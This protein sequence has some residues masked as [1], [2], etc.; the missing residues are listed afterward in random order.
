MYKDLHLQN[1]TITPRNSRT[2]NVVMNS[3]KDNEDIE[4]GFDSSG[5]FAEHSEP[6]Y[7]T[8]SNLAAEEM[9]GSKNKME[10]TYKTDGDFI[11]DSLILPQ[12]QQQNASKKKQV[13]GYSS[14]SNLQDNSDEENNGSA[15]LST[16]Y[17]SDETRFMNGAVNGSLLQQEQ[18]QQQTNGVMQKQQEQ[19]QKPKILHPGYEADGN[20]FDI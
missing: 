3:Y 17:Y 5:S 19:S 6:I 18:S 16:T 15:T 2:V 4:A 8:D 1:Q 13:Y 12:Q 9:N 11:G 10:P 7:K 14:D 20:I